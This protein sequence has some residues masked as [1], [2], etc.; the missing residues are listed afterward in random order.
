M[1]VTKHFGTANSVLI[2]VVAK[3]IDMGDFNQV[4]LINPLFSKFDRC[5]TT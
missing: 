2:S 1:F 5:M 4:C 3:L